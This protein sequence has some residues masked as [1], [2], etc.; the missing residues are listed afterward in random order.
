MN[1]FATRALARELLLPS[2]TLFVA[3][4]P[5]GR[6]SRG[7]G[8]HDVGAVAPARNLEFIL[9]DKSQCAWSA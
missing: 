5:R 6:Q 8:G 4:P 7:E 9:H 3:L 2:G 1:S